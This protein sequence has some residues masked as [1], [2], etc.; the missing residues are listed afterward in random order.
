[1]VL[2]SRSIATARALCSL[3]PSLRAL[4]NCSA[5]AGEAEADSGAERLWP[6]RVVTGLQP[7]GALHIGNYFG[8]LRRCVQLQDRGEDLMVFIAD[9]HSLT[10]HQVATTKIKL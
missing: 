1:M 6:R 7:T 3:R 5:A 10:S 8:A 9:L 2:I 4:R